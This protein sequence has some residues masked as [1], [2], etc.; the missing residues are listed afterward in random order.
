MGE[1]QDYL[2]QKEIQAIKFVIEDAAPKVFNL[3]QGMCKWL[4]EQMKD[5]NFGKKAM[6][7]MAQHGEKLMQIPLKAEN[8][9]DFEKIA[10]K[11]GV[12][13]TLV[14]SKDQCTVGFRAKDTDKMASAFKEYVS[15]VVSKEKSKKPSF[16]DKLKTAKEIAVEKLTEAVKEKI[17]N[18]AVGER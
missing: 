1:T 2:V 3:V 5:Q 4:S 8:I 6:S 16:D 10:G 18:K 14:Q 13:F 9:R 15:S 7:D 11:H 17:K 12:D